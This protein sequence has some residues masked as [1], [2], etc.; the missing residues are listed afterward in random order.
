MQKSKELDPFREVADF[1]K[2][3]GVRPGDVYL[4][5][6]P[7]ADG[8]IALL[9]GM[10][11]SV[12]DVPTLLTARTRVKTLGAE[13]RS[14]TGKKTKITK[15]TTTKFNL[16]AIVSIFRLLR[17]VSTRVRACV[18]I[19]Q[20][21]VKGKGSNAYTGFRTGCG[22]YMWPLFLLSKGYASVE[23]VAPFVWK[24]AMGLTGKDKEASRHKALG[25][26]PHGNYLLR[27]KDHN[28]AEALLL[29]E[30]TRRQ[31]GG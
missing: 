8:A 17:P 22:Y 5:I 30:Y 10:F 12:F 29:C 20:V 21:Q 1:V 13:E 28:R 24:K 25:L 16:P 18:E 6:D 4:A 26:F 19:G 7:G 23:E 11:Y 14:A 2:V 3:V 9:C 15:G 31:R 27:K